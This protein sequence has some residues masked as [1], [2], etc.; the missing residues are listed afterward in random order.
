MDDL[1]VEER[2][3]RLEARSKI[4]SERLR[5]QQKQSKERRQWQSVLY[6]LPILAVVLLAS[7]FSVKGKSGDAEY[8]IG[9]KISDVVQV[10]AAIAAAGTGWQAWTKKDDDTPDSDDDQ[11]N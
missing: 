4:L 11:I 6:L 10:I 8:S 7:G 9:L 1:T 3:E 2:L 5:K